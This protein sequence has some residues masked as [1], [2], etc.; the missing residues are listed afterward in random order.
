MLIGV[1][2][3][4]LPSAPSNRAP[5]QRSAGGVRRRPRRMKDLPAG[6]GKIGRV[7]QT[8]RL[9]ELTLCRPT[10]PP[11]FHVLMR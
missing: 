7:E 6:I 5:I 11:L 2:S 10:C 8:R 9:I 4:N 3:G 1:W